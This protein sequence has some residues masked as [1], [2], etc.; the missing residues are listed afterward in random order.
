MDSTE[1]VITKTRTL[2]LAKKDEENESV[3]A[4][5]KEKEGFGDTLLSLGKGFLERLKYRFNLE[6][7]ENKLE[8]A[9]QKL[10]RK[11]NKTEEGN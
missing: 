9:Q 4:K 8:K 6:A 10:K 7:V 1:N 5:K 2:E 3:K 11:E